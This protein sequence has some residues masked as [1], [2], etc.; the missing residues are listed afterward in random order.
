MFLS[1]YVK[2]Q[3]SRFS[4]LVPCVKTTHDI[5]PNSV[6]EVDVLLNLKWIGSERMLTLSPAYSVFSYGKI[7]KMD[8]TSW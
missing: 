2:L 5:F 3:R 1:V 8:V 6:F 7:E 4:L